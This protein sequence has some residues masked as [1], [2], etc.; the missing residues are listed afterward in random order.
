MLYNIIPKMV[1]LLALQ[2][3]AGG[4]DPVPLSVLTEQA[5]HV[6]E[7]SLKYEE[8]PRE[9]AAFIGALYSTRGGK[10]MLPGQVP[11]EQARLVWELSHYHGTDPFEVAAFLLAEN[12]G[13]EYHELEVGRYGPGGEAGPLQ[14]MPLWARE[15]EERCNRKVRKGILKRNRKGNLVKQKNPKPHHRYGNLKDC[16]YI[17]PEQTMVSRLR[18]ARQP[19]K[20]IYDVYRLSDKKRIARERV[21]TREPRKFLKKIKR[22]HKAKGEHVVVRRHRAGELIPEKVRSTERDLF[23]LEAN[24]EAGVIAFIY[25]KK[26][27]NE[28]KARNRNYTLPFWQLEY[29][30]AKG[31]RDM[32]KNEKLYRRY[33][34]AK[35]SMQRCL[36]S[37]ERVLAWEKKIREQYDR[38]LR[39]TNPGV[40]PVDTADA[41]DI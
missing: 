28:V 18:H 2:T 24:I 38:Y 37:G 9:I 32:W 35:A 3:T 20:I 27:H 40:D 25:Q 4:G 8:D 10:E 41:D 12:K 30:C 23:M 1:I 29:R 15:A 11:P 34:R 36:W 14:L 39:Y 16:L 17:G 6:W 31:V 19:D 26:K 22:E 33:P 5:G 21:K 13:R 7:L